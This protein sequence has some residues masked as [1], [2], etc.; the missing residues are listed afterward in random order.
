MSSEAWAL[1]LAAASQQ[2]AAKTLSPV[3][4]VQSCLERIARVDGNLHATAHIDAEGALHAAKAAEADMATGRPRGPLHG[5]PIAFKDLIDAKGLVTTGNSHVTAREPAT[6]DAFAVAQLRDAGA[7][8][9]GKLNT[10]E[11]ALG[12]ANGDQPLPPVRNPWHPDHGPGGSSTGSAAVVGARLCPAALGTDTGGSIRRP[13]AWCGVVGFKPSYGRVSRHGALPL[14]PSYDHIGTFSR[15]TEDAAILLGAMAGHDRRD[16]TTSTRAVPDYHAAL[17]RGIKGLKIGYAR[18][19]EDD[20]GPADPAVADGMVEAVRV[21]RDLGATVSEIRLPTPQAARAC[22]SP[23]MLA[24]V[25]ALHAERLRTR[26]QDYG[27]N[28]RLRFAVGAFVTGADY[29]RAAQGRAVIARAVNTALQQHDLLLTVTAPTTAMRYNSA[30][31]D[32]L[33]KGAGLTSVFN[34]SGH[35]AISVPAGFT[36]AGLPFGLQLAARMFDEAT[37]FAAAHAYEQAT[38]WAERRPPL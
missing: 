38:Q 25:Y 10:D 17:G 16:P 18:H 14:A 7:I 2:I 36:P 20:G 28:T 22:F 1:T 34:V 11:F 15:A 19:Y 9:L 24:E 37:L 32:D 35:P 12:A 23:M 5:I 13:A 21:L 8:I 31:P 30:T 29:V 33:L 4:L 27:R 26:W 3:E 6:E